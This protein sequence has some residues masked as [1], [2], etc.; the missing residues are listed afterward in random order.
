MEKSCKPLAPFSLEEFSFLKFVYFY[1][2]LLILI[3]REIE[4]PCGVDFM[5]EITY[6]L[7]IVSSRYRNLSAFKEKEN[8]DLKY[9]SKTVNDM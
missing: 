7:L 8:L 1:Y 6:I 2:Y 9:N 3:F 5:K 4:F